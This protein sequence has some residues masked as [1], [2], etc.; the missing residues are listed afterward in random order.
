MRANKDDFL[1]ENT[2]AAASGLSI[3]TLQRFA[4]TGYFQV[5]IGNDGARLYPK[6]E[7]EKTL[8][9]TLNISIGTDAAAPSPAIEPNK[10]IEVTLAS[11]APQKLEDDAVLQTEAN[12]L[13]TAPA[14]LKDPSKAQETGRPEKPLEPRSASESHRE[15][16]EQI[17]P[18]SPSSGEMAS[19]LYLLQLE[20]KS[21][22]LEEEL[23][24]QKSVNAMQDKLLDMKEKELDDLRAQRDWLKVRIQGLE[25]QSNR[26]QVLM[27]NE[28]QMTSKLVKIQLEKRSGIS[29]A[30]TWLGIGHSGTSEE[31]R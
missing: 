9:C 30:L 10:T 2:A 13:N 18:L 5:R 29:R 31:S 7:L 16:V 12:Q 25:D 19:R 4:E 8:G 21:Q 11:T 23:S 28:M 14:D 1:D 20:R 6:N 15:F 17:P 24:R 22:S 26:F 3:R 27:L